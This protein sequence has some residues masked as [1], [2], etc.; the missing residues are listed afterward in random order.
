MLW[1]QNPVQCYCIL[2]F[3]YYICIHHLCCYNYIQTTLINPMQ[4]FTE[5]LWLLVTLFLY[6]SQVFLFS[7]IKRGYKEL[8]RQTSHLHS[9]PSTNQSLLPLWNVI[10]NSQIRIFIL[11]SS[12]SQVLEEEKK[13]TRN[14]AWQDQNMW[15]EENHHAQNE[16]FEVHIIYLEAV[17]RILH[18]CKGESPRTKS[19][20]SFWAKSYLG[21]SRPVGRL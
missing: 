18:T 15:G 20:F 1:T 14:P 6:L 17:H 2:H 16:D 12:H 8:T 11:P 13:G 9:I 3:M 4:G 10:L 19:N 5:G 7:V 21:M